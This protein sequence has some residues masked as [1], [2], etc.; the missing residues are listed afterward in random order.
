[1]K[2]NRNRGKRAERQVAS[3]FD[4]GIRVGILGKVDVL[5]DKFIIE[6]K[7]R[8]SFSGERFLSQVEA[9]RTEYKDKIPI[10]VVHLRKTRYENSIVLIRLKDFKELLKIQA[11]EISPSN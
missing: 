8:A 6:V 5:A 7:D 1:M 3:H 2:L 11:F 4:N 9:Y 10:A